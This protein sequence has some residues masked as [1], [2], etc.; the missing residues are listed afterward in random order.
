MRYGKL[1][2]VGIAP[3]LAACATQ[4]DAKVDAIR[5]YVREVTGDDLKGPGRLRVTTR[6][7]TTDGRIAKVRGRV[8]NKFDEPV[9]GIRYVV[10]IYQQ[11]S[12][13]R[14][15][16]RWQHEVDTTLEPGQRSAMRLDIESMYFGSQGPVPFNIDAQPVKVGSRDMPPPEG[17]R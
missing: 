8:E 15:V 17:W 12:P 13:P 3:V 1:V 7:V 11:G 4:D 10:T 5:S 2:L 16:D 14:V 6:D 9:Y